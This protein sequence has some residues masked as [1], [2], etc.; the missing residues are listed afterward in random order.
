MTEPSEAVS[1]WIGPLIGLGFGIATIKML[2]NLNTTPQQQTEIGNI[3]SRSKKVPDGFLLRIY[4]KNIPKAKRILN[5]SGFKVIGE[6]ENIPGIS[7]LKFEE[8]VK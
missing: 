5:M 7:Y 2:G 1:A 8:K 6:Y 3:L 4:N